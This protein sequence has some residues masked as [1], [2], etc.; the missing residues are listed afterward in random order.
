MKRK[1]ITMLSCA[2]AAMLML[3]PLAGF[4]S[5]AEGPIV[6]LSANYEELVPG[7]LGFL[8]S[9]FPGVDFTITCMSSGNLA[10][11]VQAEG[12]VTEADILYAL[13]SG[14]AN[15]LKKEGLLRAY[16]PGSTYLPEYD[17]PESIC[18]PSGVWCGAILVNTEELA[19]LNLPEPKSYADLLDPVY[20]GHIVMCNPESSSTGYFFL[21]GLLNLYGEDAGWEYFGKL[22]ENI[23]QFTQSGSGPA[24]MV[25]MGECVIGLGMDYQGLR[26]QEAGKPVKVLFA[27][28]GAPYDN[29]TILLVAKDSE[30][31]ELVLEVLKAMTSPEG[32]AVFNDY[33]KAV[34]AGAEDNAAYSDDFKVL[35]MTGIQD[36][37]RK[38]E[39]LAIWSEKFE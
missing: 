1:Y 23:M 25:E 20:K 24:S 28:E 22:N 9:K 21:Y 6:I 5:G 3:L 37:E 30:P 15:T 29:D 38:A 4:A 10:A 33:S 11:K 14:Y 39:L 35:D 12:K 36:A 7:Q 34:I 13:S 17:D 31:S 18:I 26:L 19:K 8:Q 32:N 16:T 2:L 27:E